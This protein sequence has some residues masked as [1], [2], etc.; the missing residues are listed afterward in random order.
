MIDYRKYT[1]QYCTLATSNPRLVKFY[2]VMSKTV[3]LKGDIYKY[4]SVECSNQKLPCSNY[5]IKTIKTR[6][7][8]AKGKVL[9]LSVAFKCDQYCKNPFRIFRHTFKSLLINTF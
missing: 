5:Y 7:E 4:R 1:N 8:S 6:P 3:F 9:I 2:F